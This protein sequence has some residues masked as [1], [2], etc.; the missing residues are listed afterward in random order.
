MIASN[1]RLCWR[2]IV[3]TAGALSGGRRTA[4]AVASALGE[5]RK[6]GRLTQ[7]CGS[8]PKPRS[9]SGTSFANHDSLARSRLSFSITYYPRLLQLSST[10]FVAQ[11]SA[12]SHS[13]FRA[14]HGQST[15]RSAQSKVHRALYTAAIPPPAPPPHYTD[16]PHSRCPS[17]YGSAPPT[18]C[19]PSLCPTTPPFQTSSAL[20]Q[21]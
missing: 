14:Q 5:T 11:Y 18:A 1:R 16:N 2:L 15:A 21:P 17:A 12:A 4:G 20:S 7:G 19:T 13:T 6:P 3:V 10:F 9:G 8:V